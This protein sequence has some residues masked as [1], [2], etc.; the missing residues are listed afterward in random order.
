MLDQ[1]AHV[2]R[3]VTA[4]AVAISWIVFGVLFL[5]RAPRT[6]T[7]VRARRPGALWGILLQCCG[8][9]LVWVVRRPLATSFVPW[10]PVVDVMVAAL[11][12]LL[13]FGSL[14]FI[15]GARHGLGRQWSA[16][17][18]LVEGHELITVGPYAHVR[19]PI[20]AGML[21]MLLATGL[22]LSRP[23]ALLGGMLLVLVGTAIRTR[24]EEQLLRQAFGPTSDSMPSESQP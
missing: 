4:A 24:I 10:G 23:L 6:R 2:A 1:V 3:E 15:L 8:Y 21:G 22:A 7:A 19:H 12:V 18:R 17:A 13:A 5:I 11:V 16:S 20:Y 14:W 9:I